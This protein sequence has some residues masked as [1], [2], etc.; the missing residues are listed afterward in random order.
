MPIWMRIEEEGAKLLRALFGASFESFNHFEQ[1][2]MILQSRCLAMADI[3]NICFCV[4]TI[5]LEEGA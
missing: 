4:A 2:R 1:R 3:R 5:M